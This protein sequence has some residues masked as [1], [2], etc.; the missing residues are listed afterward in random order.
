VRQYQINESDL[1]YMESAMPSLCIRC[2]ELLNDT[3][4]RMKFRRFKDILSN[5]RWDYG[6]PEEVMKI[7]GDTQ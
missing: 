7:E 5:V 3:D 2:G 1:E 4:V 6:P